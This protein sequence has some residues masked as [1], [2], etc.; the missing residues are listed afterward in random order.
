MVSTYLSYQVYAR[1]MDRS[2]A[3]IEADPMV[4]REAQYYRDTIGTIASIDDLLDDYRLFSYAM[5]S[6]GLDDMIYAKAFMRK[7]LE[8]DLKDAE[9][10]ANKLADTRYAEFARTF[11]FGTDGKVTPTPAK[12]QASYQTDDVAELYSESRLRR[13]TL[14]AA[15]TAYYKERLAVVAS[16]DEMLA[17]DR[18]FAYALTAYGIDPVHAS[19]ATI[20][21]VLLSDLSDPGSTANT[22]GAKYAALAAAFDFQP[23]GSVAAGGS[24]Q[25]A[26]ALLQTQ[27][28]YYEKSGNDAS[29]AVAALRAS[30]YREKLPMVTTVDDLIADRKLFDVAVTAAGLDAVLQPPQLIRDVLTSDLSDPASVANTKG[31]AYRVLAEAFSFNADGTVNGAAQSTAQIE[32]T[33]S[34][35]FVTQDDKAEFVERLS[36]T[37]YKTRINTIKTVDEMLNDASLYAYLLKAFDLDAATVTKSTLRRALTSDLSNRFSFANTAA[38]KP[39]RAMAEAFNFNADGTVGL[40]RVAQTDKAREATIERYAKGLDL[41]DEAAV[42]KVRKASLYYQDTIADIR[43][44]DDLIKDKQLVAYLVKAYGLEEEQVT[45]R[46][47]RDTLTSDPF[48]KDSFASTQEND[49]FRQLAAAF[50]FT[51]EGA[52]AASATLQPQTR[53]DLIRAADS[54]LRQT[55]ELQAGEEN[56]GVRLALYFE[57]KAPV[58][59]TA[60]DILADKAIYE[61]VRTALGLPLAVAQASTEAQAAMIEKRLK[62]ADLQDPKKLARFLTQFATL[63]D[64]ENGNSSATSLVSLI[65]PVRL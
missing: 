35:Y 56:Q 25:T 54:Y 30:Y 42:D 53:G 32:K 28:N 43:A 1:D 2:M 10:F 7:V 5:R 47:L 44:V 8:S 49:G 63:Y 39:Y 23:D 19:K 58:I 6:A 21:D 61:V 16:V 55:M 27:F 13:G 24:A 4:A 52:L 14:A 64:M 48:D 40:A 46:V 34:R 18:L 31:G 50:N 3:R 65:G 38:G 26:E 45:D 41:K 36:T 51:A 11:N 20:R 15:E 60:M 22:L 9:S 12:A 29:P 57:R 17:N 62:I 59:D 33:I 37:T